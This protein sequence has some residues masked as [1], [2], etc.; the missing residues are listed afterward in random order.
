MD[1]TTRQ[2]IKAIEFL[3]AAGHISAPDNH[4]G[5]WTFQEDSEIHIVLTEALEQAKVISGVCHSSPE[6]LRT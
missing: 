5:R 2:L 1:H 6:T 4:P 3:L